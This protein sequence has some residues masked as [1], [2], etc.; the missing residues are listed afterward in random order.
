MKMVF[1]LVVL[2][3][4]AALGFWLWTVLFPSPEKAIL[5]KI[6]G[7]AATATISASDG[8][9]IRATKVGNLIGYF[10]T[11]AE[12][13]FDVS[14]YPAHTFSGR[15]EIREAAAGGFTSLTTLNVQFLDASVRIGADKQTAEVS[16][17]AR[18][19]GSD[20]KDYGVQD[21]SRFS[22]PINSRTSP[23]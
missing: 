23:R 8:N 1:R 17:T 16:C 2:A 10:S 4:T 18:V 13:S 3:A 21:N 9:I 20:K 7:L 6:S 11:D 12:I 14:G 5:K 22:S 15:D 19:Y